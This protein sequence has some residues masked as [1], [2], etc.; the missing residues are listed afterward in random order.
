MIVSTSFECMYSSIRPCNEE[1]TNAFYK[2]SRNFGSNKVQKQIL[3][4]FLDSSLFAGR[5]LK[6][7]TV[8]QRS[9]HYFFDSK[10]PSDVN[11][12]LQNALQVLNCY[13][14]YYF[15]CTEYHRS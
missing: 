6:I 1:E 11:F 15:Y 10:R 5:P 9:L 3:T 7:S 12:D 4:P 14:H 2:V 13:Y 8:L